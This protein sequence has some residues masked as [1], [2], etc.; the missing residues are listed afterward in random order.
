MMVALEERTACDTRRLRGRHVRHRADMVR[1]ALGV[2][3]A[4]KDSKTRTVV[5]AHG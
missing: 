5:Q 2:L 4:R 1:T 3:E